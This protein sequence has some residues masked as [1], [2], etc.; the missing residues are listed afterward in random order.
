[1]KK[2]AMD[3][4][5]ESLM[6]ERDTIGSILEYL[7]EDAFAKAVDMLCDCGKAITSACGSSGVATEKFAHTLN[8]IERD[9][10]FLS[11]AKA[12]HGGMGCIK[13]GDV[14]VLASRGGKT[15]ELLPIAD[16]VGKKGAKLIVVTEREDS[17]L[18]LA[19]DVVLKI[20]IAREADPLDVMATSS[21]IAMAALFDA[22]IAAIMT[23]TGYEI[24]QF[25]LIHPGGAVGE[26]LNK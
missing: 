21:F 5:R 10:V 11:P 14:V 22:L 9:G 7:D 13:R 23:Q 16:A 25:A 19:A 8:C 18:G 17:A 26:R 4:A 15:A 6:I 3:A 12:L 1:M 20:D 24:G 2:E